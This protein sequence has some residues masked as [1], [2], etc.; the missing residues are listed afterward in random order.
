MKLNSDQE[1]RA[2]EFVQQMMNRK[3]DALDIAR[4]LIYLRDELAKMRKN[5]KDLIRVSGRY[6][7]KHSEHPVI[8]EASRL[9]ET[10]A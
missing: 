3:H 8:R 6:V 7:D 9:L 1:R 4:E 2:E 5:I 10:P